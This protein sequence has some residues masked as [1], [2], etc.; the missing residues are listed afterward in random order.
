MLYVMYMYLYKHFLFSNTLFAQNTLYKH[1]LCTHESRH[2]LNSKHILFKG[3]YKLQMLLI[4]HNNI[5][6]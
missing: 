1:V 3:E 6:A 5:L 2:F 4:I